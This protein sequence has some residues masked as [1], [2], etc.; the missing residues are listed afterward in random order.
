MHIQLKRNLED[1]VLTE[2][3]FF[4]YYTTWFDKILNKNM[5]KFLQVKVL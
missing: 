5:I 3:Y 4:Y 2:K 1:V